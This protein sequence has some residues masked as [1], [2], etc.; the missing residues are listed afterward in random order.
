[1][2]GTGGGFSVRPRVGFSG[3][4]QAELELRILREMERGRE[5]WL[6]TW[7]GAVVGREGDM[8]LNLETM[9]GGAAE[10]WSRLWSTLCDTVES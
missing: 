7:F 8:P 3:T 6:L 9:G 4:L 2:D 1:M 10:S 5:V